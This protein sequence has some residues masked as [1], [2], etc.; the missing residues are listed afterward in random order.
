[1]PQKRSDLFKVS[2]SC[3]EPEVPDPSPCFLVHRAL[4]ICEVVQGRCL[5][6]LT[7]YRDQGQLPGLPSST[8]P[9]IGWF[10]LGRAARRK[11][12]GE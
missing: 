7:R 2:H 3:S 8:T 9:L 5:L 11:E 12:A 6:L 4:Q 1:M 10:Q